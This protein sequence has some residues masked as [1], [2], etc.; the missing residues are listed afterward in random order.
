MEDWLLHSWQERETVNCEVEFGRRANKWATDR[1]GLA[2]PRELTGEEVALL[3]EIN[4]SEN[5]WI[6]QAYFISEQNSW[7]EKC[8]QLEIWIFFQYSSGKSK[9]FNWCQDMITN[10]YQWILS[11]ATRSAISGKSII[12]RHWRRQRHII[13]WTSKDLISHIEE[14]Q[15]DLQYNF[16]RK[17]WETSRLKT[18]DYHSGCG[19]FSLVKLSPIHITRVGGSI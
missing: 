11:L 13:S 19:N 14:V 16:W 17:T 9:P 8:M 5:H 1:F 15:C 12:A 10:T 4:V 7:F 2:V 18:L 6:Q 3:K